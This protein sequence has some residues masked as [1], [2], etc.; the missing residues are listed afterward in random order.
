MYKD[1]VEMRDVGHYLEE[2]DMVRHDV[3]TTPSTIRVGRFRVLYRT[4]S[5]TYTDILVFCNTF[6]AVL[7]KLSRSYFVC[8]LAG[9]HRSDR[10]LERDV[11]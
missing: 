9:R 3:I 7:C 10:R 1:R 5:L 6:L 2:D 11:M 8:L 4:H